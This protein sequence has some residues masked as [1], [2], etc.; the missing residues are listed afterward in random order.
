MP[1]L[2]MCRL[3]LLLATGL[4]QQVALVF[5]SKLLEA[6]VLVEVEKA[7]VQVRTETLAAVGLVA[8]WRKVS[9]M[10]M[11]CLPH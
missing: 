8:L 4:N 2:L 10:E 6:V 5:L 9:T 3:L 1:L 11:R 7:G